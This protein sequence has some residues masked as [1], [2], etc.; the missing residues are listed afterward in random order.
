MVPTVSRMPEQERK[1]SQRR[2]G[3]YPPSLRGSM[4][5]WAAS[6]ARSRPASPA[7]ASLSAMRWLAATWRARDS[8]YCDDTSSRRLL[9][10]ETSSVSRPA[11]ASSVRWASKRGRDG[12][13]PSRS[14][15][16]SRYEATEVWMS[17]ASCVSLAPV[18]SSEED[19]IV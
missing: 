19:A 1:T 17:A 4:P 9:G 16:C 12:S 2:E 18:A 13:D 6:V 11:A 10:D 5:T 15:W 7:A 3:V 8:K 14:C